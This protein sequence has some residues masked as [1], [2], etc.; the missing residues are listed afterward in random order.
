[1]PCRRS[2]RALTEASGSRCNTRPRSGAHPGE[3]D[4]FA[5]KD[6]R[7]FNIYWSKSLSPKPSTLAGFAL[8]I[9]RVIFHAAKDELLSLI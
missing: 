7:Q 4:H 6:S 5:E 2:R 3:V 9:L 1:M 8:R